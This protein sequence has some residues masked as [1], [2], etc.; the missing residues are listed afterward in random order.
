MDDNNPFAAWQDIWLQTNR[1]QI[2]FLPPTTLEEVEKRLLE[3]HSVE[4][5]LQAQQQAIQLQKTL[6]NQQKLVLQSM[7][8]PPK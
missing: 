6:L 3:L 2:P 1:P 4:I 5:W 8:P 7:Q